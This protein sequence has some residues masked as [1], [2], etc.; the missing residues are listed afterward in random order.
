MFF[1]FTSK[2]NVASMVRVF[3]VGFFSIVIV[4]LCP[5][6]SKDKE[7]GLGHDLEGEYSVPGSGTIDLKITSIGTD[8]IEIEYLTSFNFLYGHPFSLVENKFKFKLTKGLGT[9]IDLARAAQEIQVKDVL[10][11]TI[12]Q[13]N[14]SAKG[15]FTPN[16]S[17]DSAGSSLTIQ[18]YNLGG[19]ELDDGLIFMVYAKQ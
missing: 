8:E 16:P 12:K 3:S 13:F 9:T 7:N 2:T 1:E 10:D 14:G 17:G 6:C 15:T 4:L 11:N 5:N 19:I 18:F